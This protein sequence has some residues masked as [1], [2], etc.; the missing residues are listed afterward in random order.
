MDDKQP[1][2]QANEGEGSKSA[3]K[4]Y[5]EAATDFARRNDTV[6]SG[7]AAEREVENYRDEFDKAETIGRAHSAGDLKSDLIDF[8]TK[9]I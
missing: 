7:L 9:K 4:N 5:R 3:D 8:G 2:G 6:K 1:K